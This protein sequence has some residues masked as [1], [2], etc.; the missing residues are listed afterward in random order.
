M[1]RAVIGGIINHRNC[2]DCSLFPLQTNYICVGPMF[3]SLRAAMCGKGSNPSRIPV[4]PIWGSQ[5]IPRRQTICPDTKYGGNEC[6]K[7]RN[8]H[9]R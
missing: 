9:W 3:S 8:P 4:A 6:A 5:A 1:A 7:P 2:T